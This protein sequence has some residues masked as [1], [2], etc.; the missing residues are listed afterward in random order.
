MHVSYD[1]L[2]K[3]NKDN[4]NT[5]KNLKMLSQ[6]HIIKDTCIH[7]KEPTT[8]NHDKVSYYDVQ[9]AHIVHTGENI[10]KPKVPK[11][12]IETQTSTYTEQQ[13][14]KLNTDK[15]GIQTQTKNGI[16]YKITP[17]DMN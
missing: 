17:V 6:P 16:K 4:M 2:S 15:N 14:T 5:A 12:N 7:N 3:N 8:K 10:N 13:N 11:V 1:N 9:G